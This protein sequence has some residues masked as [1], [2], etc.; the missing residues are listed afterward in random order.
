MTN[1]NNVPTV[2]LVHGWT[3]KHHVFSKLTNEFVTAGYR[4][5]AP[6]MPGFGGE[7]EPTGVWGVYDYANWLSSYVSNISGPVILLGHSFGGAICALVATKNLSNVLGL[8]V[9]SPSGIRTTS[10]VKR[11]RFFIIHSISHILKL[12]GLLAFRTR[13]Q[14]V[15]YKI[16]GATDYAQASVHMKNVLARVV[17][18]DISSDLGN[19]HIPTLII[20]AQ[21]D[22]AT[23]ISQSLVWRKN[24][25]QSTYIEV[26]GAN[27]SFIYDAPQ[28]VIPAVNE[29]VQLAVGTQ[30]Q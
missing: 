26:A 11:I 16:S 30:K 24:I 12:P 19:I 13:L 25:P 22:T 28:L 20:W 1:S 29:F 21:N 9:V 4:V 15:W 5:Y 14:R 7:P 3:Y 23:P 8:V 2:V 18:Q 27:H 17:S 6:D 10:T